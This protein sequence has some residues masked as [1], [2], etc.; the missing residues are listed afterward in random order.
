[1]QHVFGPVVSRRLGLS[2]G[3][4]PVPLKTCN[5]NCMYCQLGSTSPKRK[6]K[7]N[8][9]PSVDSVLHEVRETLDLVEVVDHVTVSGSGEPTLYPE[10]GS[11]IGGIKAMTNIPVAVITNGT[12][13][14]SREVREAVCQADVVLPSL[15]AAENRIFN[16]IA[17][18]HGGLN[19]EDVIAG[20]VAF[21]RQFNGQL[22]LEVFLIRGL[23]DTSGQVY[24]LK[25]AVDTIKP[26]R[27]HLNTVVRPP[28]TDGALPVPSDRM[29]DIASYFGPRCEAMTDED[30][31]SYFGPRCKV[32]TDGPR[33][34]LRTV[35]EDMAERIIQA[36][37]RR[38]MTMRDLAES[39]GTIPAMVL[40]LIGRL[41]FAG[42]IH[43]RD[44]GGKLYYF[45]NNESHWKVL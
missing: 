19:V 21:R 13:L 1:M 18:P 39:L 37:K 28:A 9:F 12:L 31:T 44:F 24:N 16:R 7:S 4:D 36:V 11:L 45:S 32:K 10:I 43:E 20:L 29:E 40:P 17:R 41:R 35:S 3:V 38:P 27:I 14:S 30:A 2:L 26:D 15:D 5:L 6:K 8:V 34:E 23:N 42:L 33:K 22:W 25:V